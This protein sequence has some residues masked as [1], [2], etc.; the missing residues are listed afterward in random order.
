MQT[1]RFRNRLGTEI[2]PHHGK[3]QGSQERG[4]MAA[5]AARYQHLGG[6]LWRL[7]MLRE[8]QLQRRRR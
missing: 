8:E 5:A 6:G 2:Q 4:F 7:R 1:A 3:A